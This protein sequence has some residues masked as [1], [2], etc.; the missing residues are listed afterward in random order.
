MLPP[1]IDSFVTSKF[2]TPGEC[3]CGRSKPCRKYFCVRCGVGNLCSIFFDATPRNLNLGVMM[4]CGH[5]P[6]L[7]VRLTSH[8]NSIRVEDIEEHVAVIGVQDYTINYSQ[9]YFLRSRA[10]EPCVDSEKRA[11]KK[12]PCVLG[13]C[14]MCTKDTS[15]TQ[16]LLCSFECMLQAKCKDRCATCGEAF[17]KGNKGPPTPS[18]IS[19]CSLECMVQAAE[20]GHLEEVVAHQPP[21]KPTMTP[22]LLPQPTLEENSKEAKPSKELGNCIGPAITVPPPII[23]EVKREEEFFKGV[24][25]SRKLVCM[26]RFAAAPS[27]QMT[28]IELPLANANGAST[29]QEKPCAF[30]SKTRQEAERGGPALGSQPSTTHSSEMLKHGGKRSGLMTRSPLGEEENNKCPKTS[31]QQSPGNV[32][33]ALLAWEAKKMYGPGSVNTSRNER[34]E[35]TTAEGVGVV[36]AHIVTGHCNC[37][38]TPNEATSPRYGLH[39]LASAA[40]QISSM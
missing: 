13:S 12:K 32:M 17:N 21:R 36:G 25:K 9:V 20:K 27:P 30:E 2:F 31:Q 37:W 23:N 22:K 39:L 38:L 18:R 5:S 24:T 40:E 8:R 10:R 28:R 6:R 33:L 15:V 34:N 29:S 4:H 14:A 1:W 3:G 26:M 16:E 19:F 11:V 7:Q 35:D